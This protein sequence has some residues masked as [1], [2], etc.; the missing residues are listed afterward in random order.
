[1]NFLSSLHDL[2]QIQDQ[3]AVELIPLFDSHKSA[4]NTLETNTLKVKVRSGEK[5]EEEMRCFNSSIQEKIY[6]FERK[7]CPYQFSPRI[8]LTLYQTIKT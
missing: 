5:S 3:K 6:Q 8:K 4:F 2:N 7:T 1:M